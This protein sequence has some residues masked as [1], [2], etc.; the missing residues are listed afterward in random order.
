[1]NGRTNTSHVPQQ[2]P[3]TP[4]GK[5]PLRT[6]VIVHGQADLLQVVRAL[7]TPGGF[8]G[9]LDGGQEQRD[10]DRDDGDH[11]EQLDQGEPEAAVTH[12]LMIL[13]LMKK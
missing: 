10:Q 3:L 7:G 5:D 13:L 9:R 11:D 12:D 6:F 8:P 4:G 2:H 1:M